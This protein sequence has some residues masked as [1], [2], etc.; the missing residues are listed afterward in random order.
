MGIKR[1]DKKSYPYLFL[2]QFVAFWHNRVFYRRIVILNRENIPK[3]AHL[4]FTGN[5]QNA[6][7]DALVFLHGYK[8]RLVFLARSDIFKNPFIAAIL[9][10][11]RMLPV[12][13]IKDGYSAVKKNDDI[14]QKTIDV[15]KNK[16]GLVI[17]AEG[18]HGEQHRLRTL[19]K[20]FA[21][22]AFQTEEANDFQLDMK[23]IPVG[24][25][26]S[27]YQNF[28][29]ELLINFGNPIPVSDY[30]DAY[31]ESP[32]IAINQMKEQLAD[33]L[34][35]LMVH[36]KSEK[37]YELYNQLREIYKHEMAQKMGFP[38]SNQPYKLQMDQEL[39]RRL[40][41]FEEKYPE[42]M[43]DFQALVLRYQQNIQKEKLSY[44]I[45]R[46][47]VG[48]NTLLIIETL[49]FVLASP[50]FVLGWILNY[51][52]FGLSIY[53]GLKMKDPQFK[54]S[55]KFVLSMFVWPLFHLIETWVVWLIFTDWMLAL[56]F[57][58]AMPILGI[59]ARWYWI[60]LLE[61]KEAFRWARLKKN[62]AEVYQMI[63]KDQK[64]ILNKMKAIVAQ[65]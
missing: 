44:A 34:I 8:G 31:K 54:S 1:I 26:Y 45:V 63:R 40:E 42:Q 57:F 30:Y 47:K 33:S 36:I 58:I 18:N 50:M 22:I 59:F 52:P 37:H 3:N 28:R 55:V 41:L 29:T 24:I 17:M 56:A 10:F 46:N 64:E 43:D 13:R 14:F 2:K 62:K 23:V 7:M 60:S 35:P 27:N 49:L 65:N 6:L 51:I 15:I 4:I 32:A 11:L 61:F 25:D 53:I 12:F 48:S 5:H 19:K 38:S 21:R 20:G 39:I 16:I 9:Y